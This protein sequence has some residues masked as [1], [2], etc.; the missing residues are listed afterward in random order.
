MLHW[1]STFFFCSTSSSSSFAPKE[2]RI[3]INFMSD[4][5]Q[6]FLVDFFFALGVLLVARGGVG[7][8]RFQIRILC[9]KRVSFWQFFLWTGNLIGIIIVSLRVIHGDDKLQDIIGLTKVD[10]SEIGYLRILMMFFLGSF[11]N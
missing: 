4:W 9:G 1:V 2:A 7:G 10:E 3:S 6:V 5:Q 8:K 11:C